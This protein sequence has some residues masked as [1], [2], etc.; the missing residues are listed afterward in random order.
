MKKIVA[1]VVLVAG[2]RANADVVR[3]STGDADV[4][5]HS[6]AFSQ[7]S[8]DTG[9]FPGSSPAQLRLTARLAGQTTV[10]MGLASTACWDG[11]M[12]ARISGR[13][14]AGMLDFAYGAE[15]HLFGQIHTSVLG[16]AI[17][18]SGEIPLPTDYLVGHTTTF[19]PVLL[20]GATVDHVS[21]SD[22]TSALTLL[23]SNVIGDLIDITGISGGLHLDAVGALTTSYRTTQVTL[24]A[25]P[26]T[27][28]DGAAVVT[29]PASGFGPAIELP[30]AASGVITY[31]PALTFNV[32][33]NVKILGITVANWT[34]YSMTVPLPKIDDP[35]VL[36][37]DQAHIPLP[38]A[39]VLAGAHVDF[40]TGTTQ[41]LAIHNA[42]EAPLMLEATHSSVGVTAALVTIAPGADGMLTLTAPANVATGEVVIATNDPAQPT[43]TLSVG[44]DI[45]GTGIPDDNAVE[46]S[47]CNVGGRQSGGVLGLAL[48][49]IL[50]RRR[51]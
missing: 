41:T 2:N 11:P 25:S 8:G 48:V 34:L 5:Y 42:G 21:G 32:G 1:L 38:K 10:A 23:S 13:A 44:R 36:A 4:H 29:T 19:D 37:G 39:P 17:D 46:H 47:G 40:A 30:A 9:W 50:R 35:V 26:I 43:V 14:G 51:R 18:W 6:E 12:T 22:T 31:T 15:L 45:G 16:H 49:A 27:T 3:C 24:G 20:P 7:L 33:F 28:A